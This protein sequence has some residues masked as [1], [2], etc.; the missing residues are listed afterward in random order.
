MPAP[1]NDAERVAAFAADRLALAGSQLCE[2]YY[3]QSLTLCVI[4]AVFSINARY[5]AVQNAVQRYC[6]AF[7]LQRIRPDR[8]R[9]PPTGQQDSVVE[10]CRRCDDLGA[11]RLAAGVFCNRQRTSARGGILKAEAVCR[12]ARVLA[13]HRINFL[14][15]VPPA[16]ESAAVEREVREIPG[17]RSGLSLTYLWMLAGSDD[18]VKADRMILRFLGRA[19]GRKVETPEAQGLLTEATTLLIPA[20]PHLTPRL[21]DYE[22]WKAESGTADD[23]AR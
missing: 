21:L 4:N 15:D 7:G 18:H 5:K 11:E 8:T 1:R 19:L 3:Y 20:H 6:G 17:Q 22:I 16:M 12:F 13:K 2:D 9:L 14:Q 10:L 23:P